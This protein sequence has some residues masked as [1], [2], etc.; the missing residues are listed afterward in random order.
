MPQLL[1]KKRKKKK[2]KKKKQSRNKRRR[3]FKQ[4]H[5]ENLNLQFYECIIISNIIIYV[6]LYLL[7][8]C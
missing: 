2:K 3:S 6:Q 1:K 8:K 7:S 4:L 5:K